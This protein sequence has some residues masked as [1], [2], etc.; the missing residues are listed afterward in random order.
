M[1]ARCMICPMAAFLG[2]VVAQEIGREDYVYIGLLL[3]WSGMR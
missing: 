3:C 1:F 2:G